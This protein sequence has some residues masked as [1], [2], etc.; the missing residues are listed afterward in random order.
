[1]LKVAL[2]GVGGV[3]KVHVSAWKRLG[4]TAEVIAVADKDPDL[5]RAAAEP[6]GA[7]MYLSDT[8]LFANEK[9]D[10][11]DIC[12]PTHL[13]VDVIIRAAQNGADVLCEKPFA[14]TADD[15]ARAIDAVKKYGKRLMIAHVIRFWPEYMYLRRSIIE[16]PYGPLMG[17]TMTRISGRRKGMAFEDWPNRE[18]LSGSCVLDQNIHD[19]DFILSVLG[20]PDRFHA[21]LYYHHDNPEHMNCIMHFGKVIVN[22]D[23][24]W[25]YPRGN[26]FPF[27]MGFRANF[28]R[29]ALVYDGRAN[30]TL[31]WYTDDGLFIPLKDAYGVTDQGDIA[32]VPEGEGY[33][34]E[35][36]YFLRCIVN[37]EPFTLCPPE[38]AMASVRFCE[39]LIREG[40]ANI[41]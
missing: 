32:Q 12:V 6:F 5:C 20:E 27:T 21:G 7:R 15:A 33:Y 8:D 38:E 41:Q 13:H 40:K 36:A 9:P 35:I 39:R 22:T 1:M 11:V 30:P 3:S 26:I 24:G 31:V 17:M 37:K 19:I 25:N 16:Q 29:G 28:E 4:E 34:N 14:R 23:S 18:E 10:I 2:I